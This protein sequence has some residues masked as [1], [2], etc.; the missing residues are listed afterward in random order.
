MTEGLKSE[1]FVRGARA[2]F[3]R[4][5]QE[6]GSAMAARNP[7]PR[8]RL[9]TM[10]ETTYVAEANQG[11]ADLAKAREDD[12]AELRVVVEAGG[13]AQADHDAGRV[14]PT[15][16]NVPWPPGTLIAV[17]GLAIAL[18]LFVDA[19]VMEQPWRDAM[20]LSDQGD[21]ARRYLP[22]VMLALTLAVFAWISAL[23]GDRVA[24][25]RTSAGRIKGWAMAI[26]GAGLMVAPVIGAAAIR[27]MGEANRVA[28]VG[29]VVRAENGITF[30]MV[31]ALLAA[32]TLGLSHLRHLL[33]RRRARR[34]HDRYQRDVIAAGQRA[35]SD[36]KT[37]EGGEPRQ[38]ER[39]LWA[40]TGG[41][42]V[43]RKTVEEEMVDPTG[44][45][46]WAERNGEDFARIRFNGGGPPPALP[47]GT[48]ADDRELDEGGDA[49]DADDAPGVDQPSADA[50]V[51]APD[52]PVEHGVDDDRATEEDVPDDAVGFDAGEREAGSAWDDLIN[53]EED[54]AA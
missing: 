41:A 8:V 51:P 4:R 2:V 32:V 31:Q 43:L 5:G 49:R 1:S 10:E 20:H 7:A 14:T 16:S 37:F 25:S 13:R 36:L 11:L 53:P 19:I 42:I 3:E 21:L 22:P 26:I 33:I 38:R 24:E 46:L 15:P 54:E 35:M 52:G 34:R 45:A 40:I 39:L 23:G 9:P 29:G 12:D 30:L 50:D 17:I 18:G 48:L 6:L 28:S 44:A 27:T 47:F